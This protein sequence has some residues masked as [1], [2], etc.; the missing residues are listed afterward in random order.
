METRIE[1]KRMT[2]RENERKY[3]RQIGI[4]HKR[5]RENRDKN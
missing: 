2:K 5:K 1:S 3:K 4:E